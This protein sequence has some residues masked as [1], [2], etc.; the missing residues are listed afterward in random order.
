M[1]TFRE[2]LQVL[3]DARPEIR[4]VEV[5]NRMSSNS[6]FTGYLKG[7]CVPNALN[8]YTMSKY[9]HVSTMYLLGL[10]DDLSYAHYEAKPYA[11][12]ERFYSE[13][14][15][16][17]DHATVATSLGITKKKLD[18]LIHDGM[19]PVLR[20]F[21]RICEVFN[22]HP[23][24]LLGEYDDKQPCPPLDDAFVMASPFYK[25]DHVDTVFHKNLC[26]AID[27]RSTNNKELSLRVGKEFAYISFILTHGGYPSCRTLA[28]ICTI[29]HVS[30]DWLF[31]RSDKMDIVGDCV[32][33]APDARLPVYEMTKHMKPRNLPA[34]ADKHNVSID[35]LIGLTDEK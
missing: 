26:D 12:A 14:Y 16:L 17:V 29:L 30:A 22:V 20:L 6:L 5:A 35:Y 18:K 23:A 15:V 7:E 31:G 33:R 28:D 32:K 25:H 19:V 1:N 13:Y 10:S 34:F 8:L 2:R 9:Y 21:L 4:R 11:F 27:M 24:Y 3:M